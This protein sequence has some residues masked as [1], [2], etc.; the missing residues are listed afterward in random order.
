[1]ATKTSLGMRPLGD[2][3]V[4]KPLEA[5]EETVSVSGIIIPDSDKKEKPSKGKV[6]AVGAGR[7]T[8]KGERISMEVKVGDTVL[9]KRPWDEPVK[10]EG[11]EYYI[12]SESEITVVLD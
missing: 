3:V 12:L 7:M 1:M 6:V 9:F 2:R 5:K 8:E 4:V 10:I 11:V